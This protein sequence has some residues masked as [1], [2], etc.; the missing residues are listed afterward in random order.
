M[1]ISQILKKFKIV[2]VV[3]VSRD[4]SKDSRMVLGYL[5]AHGF[6]AY[7]VNPFAEE[8][9]GHKC[10]KSLS[11]LPKTPEIVDVF[12]PSAEVMPIVDEAIK[13][14]A[15]AIWMQLGVINEEAAQKAKKAGLEVVM[16]HCMAT[17]NE[18]LRK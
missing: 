14:G 12:R 7:P 15:K 9:A 1:S 4:P 17:E 18:K 10:Y 2:A 8:I 16:N 13:V 11:E 6:E 5:L 3:G